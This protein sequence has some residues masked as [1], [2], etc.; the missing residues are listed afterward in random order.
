[1]EENTLVVVYDGIETGSHPLNL[2]E[3]RW[4]SCPPT[5]HR[6]PPPGGGGLM[7]IVIIILIVFMSWR[8]SSC[9]TGPGHSTLRLYALYCL[10]AGFAYTVVAKRCPEVR[11]TS[12]AEVRLPPKNTASFIRCISK[13]CY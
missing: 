12:S 11:I 4:H 5:P 3:A 1:M 6:H 8:N 10:L 7:K 13:R 9:N 2:C